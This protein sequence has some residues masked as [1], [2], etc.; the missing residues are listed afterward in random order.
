M[1]LLGVDVSGT[2]D[3]CVL[4]D[5]FSWGPFDQAEADAIASWHANAVG[6]PLNE[7]CWLGINGAP[8]L[9][10]GNNYQTKIKQ[11]VAE[12]NATGMVAILDL[13]WSAPGS[14]AAL[15]AWP[16][17]D[18]DH[19]VTFWSQVASA[20]ALDPS[21]VFDLFGEPYLGTEHPTSA[22]WACWRA[23]CTMPEQLCSESQCVTVTYASAGIQQLIDTV[24]A[25]GADQPIMV[26]GL[27]WAGDPCGLMDSGSNTHACAWLA[28]EP[29]DPAHQLIASFHTYNW[30]A[31]TTLACWDA[32][33]LPVAAIVPVVTGEF[34]EN[35]CSASYI[36]KYMQWAD[37]HAISYVAWSWEPPATDTATCA[38][39]N[40]KLLSSWNGTPN[41]S[42][43]A[44]PAFAAHLAK[45]A[46]GFTAP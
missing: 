8:A 44:G 21:V 29:T 45:I 23:G 43:P 11:W 24:R 32:S 37:E 4:D 36:D 14:Y 33:V 5:G 10:S 38:A 26:A 12:I 20:F 40:M 41:T 16:M 42:A 28:Y 34:G 17:P 35:D 19:S 1:R 30:T 3:A 9:Y 22:D 31:C 18:E 7:D 46:S 6:V 15:R 2:E 39:D 13:H 27:N 25:A